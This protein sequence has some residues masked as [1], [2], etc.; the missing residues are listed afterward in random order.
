M[1]HLLSHK[2]GCDEAPSEGL[3]HDLNAEKEPPVD[4]DVASDRSE[5]HEIKDD[6]A[7]GPKQESEVKDA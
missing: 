5:E 4:A 2:A 1:S 3:R 7:V 6:H